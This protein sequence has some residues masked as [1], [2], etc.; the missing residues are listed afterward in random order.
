MLT[1]VAIEKLLA[2]PK[3]REVPDGR[4]SGLYLVHQP[5]GA[6]SWALRYR[7][8]G[9]PRKLTLGPYPAVDLATAR[10]RALE[11]LG[12][13]AGGIDPAQ[14][15]QASRAAVKAAH[16]AEGDRVEKVV[17][18]FIERHAKAKTRDWR[19]TE[20]MLTKEVA[21]RWQ[22]RR[23]G[24]ITRAHVNDMLDEIIDRGH[25]VRANRVFAAF[26][27]MCNWA[28]VERGI[29]EKSPCLGMSA[30]SKETKRKRVL[31]DNEIQLAWRAFESMGWPFG[32]I[33]QLLLLTGARRDEVAGMQWQEIDLANRNWTLPAT[34]TKN[35]N[36]H[37]IP[38]S[39]AAVSI[40]EKLPRI[41]RQRYVFTT[42]GKTP[43]SGF[44]KA[45]K[46]I[47][48]AT[49]ELQGDEATPLPH[50]TLHDLRRTVA[51]N[52]Q[53]LGVRLEVTEAVLNHVSGSKAG[54]VEIYQ[55]HNW[56][57]EKRT[58]LNAWANRL[59]ESIAGE[60]ADNVVSITARF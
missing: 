15:K 1:T 39:D 38:L 54:I 17:A 43:V 32:P 48:A 56:A 51:T 16:E 60:I 8:A 37:V 44:S 52:L 27:K 47:D 11:A 14:E 22:G 25:H 5:S 26:R 41:E 46:E 3:R 58:A 2:P 24:Q 19:E 57:D 59:H 50:W 29:L 31:N 35:K 9:T 23:L 55:C 40:I 10:R 6:K 4:I 33:G 13:L 36:E 28:V 49:L 30:P 12:A 18:L 42:T 34:R 20:R 21:K 7:M 53:K 45:K